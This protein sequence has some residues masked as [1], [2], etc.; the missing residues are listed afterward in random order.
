MR[1]LHKISVA[2]AAV[3]LLGLSSPVTAQDATGT[4][5]SKLTLTT[6]CA[7]DAGGAGPSADFGT[8]DFGTHAS[9]FIGNLE[10][11]AGSVGGPTQVTCSDNYSSL[12]IKVN[13]GQNAGAGTNGVGTRSMRNGAGDYVKYEVYS[14]SNFTVPYGSS[15]ITHPA[16]AGVAFDLPLYGRVVKS[17]TAAWASGDYTD[18]L[19]VELD[20]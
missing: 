17:S 2:S 10:A 16:T 20:W 13:L 1:N 5:V 12:T 14:D 4:V 7:V 18:L 3:T 15:A 11:Q 6:G 19:T 8:L 9:T